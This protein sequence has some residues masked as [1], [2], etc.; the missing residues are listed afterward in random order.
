M[1]LN[2]HIQVFLAVYVKQ[3][4]Q[5]AFGAFH[6]VAQD[7]IRDMPRNAGRQRD[8]SLRILLEHIIIDARLKIKSFRITERDDLKRL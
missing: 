8:D 5:D 1:I 7:Q 2:F 6:V 4:Q 3:R